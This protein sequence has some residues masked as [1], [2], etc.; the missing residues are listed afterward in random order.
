MSKTK[1]WFTLRETVALIKPEQ[2]GYQMEEADAVAWLL[3]LLLSDV[4][5]QDGDTPLLPSYFFADPVEIWTNYRNGE[6]D[7]FSGLVDIWIEGASPRNMQGSPP[8][9]I[10][11]EPTTHCSPRKHGDYHITPATK[12]INYA[13]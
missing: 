11:L 13:A 12:L 8:G 1:E 4:V 7:M 10:S 3:D 5:N 6:T 9:F 2:N